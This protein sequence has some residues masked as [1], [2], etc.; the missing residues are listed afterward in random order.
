MITKER[1]D[2]IVT[3]LLD[4]ENL[5]LVDISISTDNKIVVTVD[6]D[7]GVSI[8]SCVA[9]S[10][11]IESS[12][13]RDT[14]DFE[15]EVSSAGVGQPLKMPR[16]Y[17]KNIGREL[18]VITAKGEK[19]KGKLVGADESGFTISFSK[20]V[21]VEGKKKKQLI[22]EEMSFNYSDTKSVKVVV[23]FK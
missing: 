7:D 20:K 13:D 2:E 1:I 9:V 23:S 19:F 5:F 10:R 18:E 4:K 12:L 16:Q 14:E 15:L 8:D 22:E 17:L 3:P 6:S 21:A 11:A